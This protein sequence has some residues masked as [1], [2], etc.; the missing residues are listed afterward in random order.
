MSESGNSRLIIL[1]IAGLPVTMILAATWLWFFVVKGDLDLVGAL[2]TANQGV[3]VQPPRQLG[4]AHLQALGMA[5]APGAAGEPKWLLLTPVSARC[6]EACEK[7]LY[8]TRQIHIAMGKYRPRL[9]R[10]LVS[11]APVA[12]IPLEVAALS[13]G[14]PAPRTLLG[15]IEE[16]QQGLRVL[17]MQGQAFSRFFPEYLEQPA[18]WYLVDPAGWI[19][20]SYDESVH[21]KDV[22]SDLKFLLKNYGG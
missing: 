10:A 19:M 8:R 4:P 14:A 13:G 16:Q 18:T 22:M 5:A 15:Y 20:M 9:E 3:L 12:A 17:H 6:G 7:R 1:L 21:Y 11:T 2:G